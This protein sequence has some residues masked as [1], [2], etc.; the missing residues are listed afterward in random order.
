MSINLILVYENGIKLYLQGPIGR[1][2]WVG[3]DVLKRM[4]AGKEEQKKKAD[5][6]GRLI[7]GKKGYRPD[8]LLGNGAFSRVYYAEGKDGASAVSEIFWLL[9]GGRAGFP[10]LRVYTGLY[11]G[12]NAGPA[13]AFYHRT[14]SSYGPGIGGRAEVS[15]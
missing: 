3:E 8:R 13:R 7:L 4:G 10:A 12:R 2:L 6:L 14:D 11:Y 9:E 15:A 5:S 1:L